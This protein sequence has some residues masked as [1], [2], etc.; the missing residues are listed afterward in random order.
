MGNRIVSFVDDCFYMF[1]L[2]YLTF[3]N[4]F[5]G[6]SSQQKSATHFDCFVINKLRL[7]VWLVFQQ[8]VEYVFIFVC[9]G[10]YRGTSFWNTRIH[11]YGNSCHRWLVGIGIA[12]SKYIKQNQLP[13]R[14]STVCKR[15]YT[16]NIMLMKH[17][18]LFSLKQ[19][20]VYQDS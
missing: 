4:E 10:C 9:R 7:V 2:L 8:I 17:M 15:C 5:R 12:F 3:F 11:S 1:R 18:T 13:M 16:I 19:L 14:R 6:T 20:T